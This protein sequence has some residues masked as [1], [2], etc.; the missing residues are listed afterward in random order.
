MSTGQAWLLQEGVIRMIM[1]GIFSAL[2]ELNAWWEG[3]DWLPLSTG[4]RTA[5]KCQELGT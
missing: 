1:A 4:Q 3:D 2:V 5:K